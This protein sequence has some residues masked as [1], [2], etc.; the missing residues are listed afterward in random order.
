MRIPRAT[1]LTVCSAALVAGVL[2]GDLSA[3]SPKERLHA[4]QAQAQKV[5]AQVSA[6]DR[7]FEASVE[8][9]HGAQYELAAAK[10]QLVQTR[11]E[12]RA[13]ER[14]RRIAVGR[15]EDRVVAIYESSDTPTTLGVFLGSSSVSEILD[16]LDAARHV[17][18]ADRRLA[19]Q[20]TAAR[21]R[22]AKAAAE[23]SALERQRAA[24]VAQRASERA[25]I[26]S[27][28]EQRKRLLASV[29]SEVR[30]LQAEEARRQAELA[31]Q[32]R[33]RLAA[34]QAAQRAAAQ[35]QREEAAAA[36]KERAEAAQAAAAAKKPVTTTTA[37]A[38]TTTAA[39]AADPPPPTTAPATT[40][41][42]APP[43][44]ATT[45]AVA[46]SSSPGPGHP[47]AA[48]I[49]LRYLGIKYLWG[50]ASPSTGFDCSGLVMYVYAQLGV[51]L[52]HFAAAQYGMG[53][54]VS[55][56]QLQPGDLVFFDALNHVGIYIGG[57]QFVHAPETGDVVK[58]TALSDFGSSYVGARRI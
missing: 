41:T 31:A 10:R 47:E 3:A 15:L 1:L 55:R 35:R 12:L 56:D 40:A 20:T 28:L 46:P 7:R 37:P 33:A 43:P 26:G 22:Y 30:T 58:I 45:T 44:P 52:P 38:T 49:A 34:E 14:Q 42:T 39:A 8:A 32:A 50:G 51:S 27:M 17:A 25:Q 48:T 23:T 16:E 54:P 2:A 11:A 9:W 19:A 4:K 57:G 36:A 18:D 29:Q 24:A 21:D 53:K 13:A 5:L 6:L